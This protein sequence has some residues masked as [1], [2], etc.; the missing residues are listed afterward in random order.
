MA[1]NIEIREAKASDARVLNAYIK[2]I[3]GTSDHL[4]TR[5]S[6]F[7]TGSFKQRFWITKKALH[8]SEICLLALRDGKIIGMLDSWTD[9]RARV[10]H[11]TSFAMSVKQEYRSNGVGKALLNHFILWVKKHE[12]L[13]RIELHVHSDNV[14]AQQLY[15]NLGFELEGTRRKVLR[16]EDGRVIDDHI[17]ALWP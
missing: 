16:Y 9:M 2:E 10:K 5:Q 11:S 1:A 7:R 6:E 13:E 14:A 15:K 12:T 4:I 8:P 17:M 3:Y